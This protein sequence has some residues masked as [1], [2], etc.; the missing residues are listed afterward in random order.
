MRETM[1][2]G[3]PLIRLTDCGFEDRFKPCGQ[4]FDLCSEGRLLLL[5]PWP[6]NVGRKSTSGYT[7]FH[8]M[9]DLA[10]AIAGLPSTDRLFLKGI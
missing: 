1:Q 5:A 2:L 9:N 6:D 7:E 3:L 4:D 10:L 8:Q